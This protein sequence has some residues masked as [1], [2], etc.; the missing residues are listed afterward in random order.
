[1]LNKLFKIIAV[2]VLCVYGQVN[3]IADSVYFKVLSF[4]QGKMT[5]T[6]NGWFIYF[7]GDELAYSENGECNFNGRI[8]P[9]MWH[10]FILRYKT[11]AE[12]PILNCNIYSDSPMNL[13]NPGEV[14]GEDLFYYEFEIPIDGNDTEFINPQYVLE[15]KSPD[16]K[17]S[18]ETICSF[19]GEEVLK[20]KQTILPGLK[21][22]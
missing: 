5:N 9:C 15:P 12:D 13:G 2:T 19:E 8:S 20:F 11:N 22:I 21:L 7:P 4:E 6:E 16:Y 14:L 10:G 17:S 1:M 3:A 18:R